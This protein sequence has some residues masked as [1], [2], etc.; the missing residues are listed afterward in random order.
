MSGRSNRPSLSP[1]RVA[2]TATL[3]LV[4]VD[5]NWGAAVMAKPIIVRKKLSAQL[6]EAEA[7]QLREQISDMTIEFVATA[8]V[9][10]NPRNAKK[11][12]RR[13]IELIAENMRKFG[14]NHPILIDDDN[15]IIGGHARIAAAQLL[16]LEEVPTIRFSNLSP[17]EKRAVALADNRLGELGTWNTELLSL[18]LKELTADIGELNFD[19]SLIGFETCESDQIL[20]G[21]V[22]FAKHD[23]A[24]RVSLP[25]VG[26]VAVTE[27]SDL[28]VCGDH[29]LFCGSALEAASYLALLAGT[30]AD[31]TLVDPLYNS[32]VAGPVAKR[33]NAGELP[34]SA[35]NPTSA[36]LIGFLQ[37][38]FAHIA[39]NVVDGAVIY[40]FM[41]WHHFDELS[42]AA[43]RYFGKPKNMVVWIKPKGEQ[44]A[45][46]RSQYRHIAVYVAGNAPTTNN[47]R[48]GERRG[49]RSDVWTYAGYK[50]SRQSRDGAPDATL[51]P[52][53]LVVDALRDCS[54]GGQVVLDPFA[55]FGT[56]MIAAER[57]GRRARLIEIDPNYCDLIVRRWQTFS[58]KV[59]HLA[60][61]N[62][63]FADVQ[64]RRVRAGG[65]Q[66]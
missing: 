55:G 51:T 24:D 8:S 1:P 21:K 44:V 11:H 10:S 53:E 20:G 64:A 42:A 47:F 14:F 48:F 22:S 58:G 35:S 65:G 5:E 29:S 19:I 61:S 32:P 16:K 30:P 34:I 46:Y 13:Q 23:P 43:E 37:T 27:P 25:A 2:M 54:K 62:E 4:H 59:A 7:R 18:E 17:Q 66:E 31:V 49:R 45:F 63:S 52:V 12:P 39:G 3:K 56:T 33:G 50:S 9:I 28:W 40:G 41:D 38:A 60:D 15:T 57:S 26:E 36:E 6:S